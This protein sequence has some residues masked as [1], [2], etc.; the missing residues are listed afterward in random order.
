ME[1]NIS[2]SNIVRDLEA[3]RD[4]APATTHIFKQRNAMENDIFVDDLNISALSRNCQKMAIAINQQ[5]NI[6]RILK[7]DLN[8]ALSRIE[9]LNKKLDNKQD[10]VGKQGIDYL[11]GIINKRF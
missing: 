10:D 11:N 8:I 6:I 2:S 5:N 1:S 9:S 3:S 4:N 7:K